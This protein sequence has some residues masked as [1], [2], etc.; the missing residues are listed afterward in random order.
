M[1][2]FWIFLILAVLVLIPFAIWGEDFETWFSQEGAIAWLNRYG[3]WAWAAGILLLVSD[4]FLP[5]P[6]TAVISALGY[7][8]GF[9]LGGLFGAVG[10]LL[11]GLLAYGLCRK[12]GHR[13]AE[14][15]AG[16]EGLEKGERIFAGSAGGFI[17]ALS[18]WL[19]VMPEVI[20]CL[21]GLAH[22]P[23]RRFVVSLACGSLPLGFA[24]AAIG[25]AGQSR[26]ILAL[27]LSAVVP[28]ILWV[29]VRP[30]VARRSKESQ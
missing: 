21:A 13:A 30:F 15:I 28:A 12:V 29:S 25:A 7:V 27:V 3:A 16:K 23:W 24:F 22:M 8:Y 11:S 10:S 20:A 19:P 4:L 26:P 6:G 9:W 5:V 18:R 1:R 2:L 14:W 17:I